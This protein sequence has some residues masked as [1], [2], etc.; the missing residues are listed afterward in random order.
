MPAGERM[1]RVDRDRSDGL[2]PRRPQPTN[3]CDGVPREHV[4]HVR[5]LGVA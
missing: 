2:G 4:G 5:V 3:E 1:E